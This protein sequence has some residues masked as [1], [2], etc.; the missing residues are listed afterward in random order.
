MLDEH[1]V[2]SSSLKLRGGLLYVFSLY[3]VEKSK[4][5]P[6]HCLVS[7][8]HSKS[9][10]LIELDF[11]NETYRAN[12]TVAIDSSHHCLRSPLYL[13]KLRKV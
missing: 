2:I 1:S 12:D 9:A 7:S 11:I 13:Y 4:A 10:Y 6:P 3:W 8:R 5:F